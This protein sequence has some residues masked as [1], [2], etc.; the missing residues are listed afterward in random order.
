[1]DK[2]GFEKW[3]QDAQQRSE[4]LRQR[5]EELRQRSEELRQDREN[6]QSDIEQH[7][8]ETDKFIKYF[9]QMQEAMDARFIQLYS[10]RIKREV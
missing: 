4:E 7:R 9:K 5:S 10:N 3:L 1:M 2:N 6:R 8:I